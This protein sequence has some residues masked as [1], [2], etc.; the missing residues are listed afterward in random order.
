MQNIR[1]SFAL[2]GV[3][4]DGLGAAENLEGGIALDAIFLAKVLLLGAVDLDERN[5]LLLERRRRRLVLGGERLAVTAPRC[6]D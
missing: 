4:R 1:I 6:E 5:I 3:W 2:A